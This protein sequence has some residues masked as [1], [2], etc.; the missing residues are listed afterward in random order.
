MATSKSVI[1]KISEFNYLNNDFSVSKVKLQQWFVANLISDH[2]V[3]RAI[4]ISS[5]SDETYILLRNL[6]IPREPDTE[7][8][9]ELMHKLNIHCDPVQSLFTSRKKLYH[10]AQNNTESVGE[11]AARVHSLANLCS[12]SRYA[13]DYN[14]RHICG[15]N[16]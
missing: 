4:L 6:C 2:D 14:A 12:Y 7:K 5:L 16:A 11:W 1:G 13:G 9:E 15:W 10:A 3:K 8:F